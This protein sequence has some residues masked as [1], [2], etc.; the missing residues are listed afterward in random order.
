MH[1]DGGGEATIKSTNMVAR[2]IFKVW[3]AVASCGTL[4]KVLKFCMIRCSD[5]KKQLNYFFC[6]KDSDL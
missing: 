6:R 5:L 3:T 4:Y 2:R 1:K